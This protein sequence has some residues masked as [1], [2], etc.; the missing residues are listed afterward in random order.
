LGAV[1]ASTDFAMRFNRLLN[2]SV[3]ELTF[4]VA[5]SDFDAEDG[6]VE[7]I[8]IGL[9]V[10]ALEDVVSLSLSLLKRVVINLGPRYF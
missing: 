7:V 3:A 1:V 6:I 4:V 8:V 10:N 2:W 9:A 5:L